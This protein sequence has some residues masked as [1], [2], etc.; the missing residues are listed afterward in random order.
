MSTE[1]KPPRFVY[2]SKYD[3]GHM[4]LDAMND[5]WNQVAEGTWPTEANFYKIRGDREEYFKMF[6]E[7][8]DVDYNK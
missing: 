6:D 3:F 7:Y 5:W 4:V 8:K 1:M 2:S